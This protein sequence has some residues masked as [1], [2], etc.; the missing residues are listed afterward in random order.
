ME[1]HGRRFS[2]KKPWET[3]IRKRGEKGSVL[4]VATVTGSQGWGASRF[5]MCAAKLRSSLH[6]QFQRWCP[7]NFKS[8]SKF[9]RPSATLFNT[10]PSWIYPYICQLIGSAAQHRA[11]G[12]HFPNRLGGPPV[13]SWQHHPSCYQQDFS[14]FSS[15]YPSLVC[16]GEGEPLPLSPPPLITLGTFTDGAGLETWRNPPFPLQRATH[17]RPQQFILG[18]LLIRDCSADWAITQIWDWIRS[19]A[20]DKLFNLPELVWNGYNLI[21]SR[22]SWG[23]RDSGCGNI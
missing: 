3:T 6:P 18:D 17:V 5:P 8:S 20:L 21:T 22:V 7:L 14:F 4:E 10:A 19:E 23:I 13:P 15:R 16:L 11:L 2:Q 12:E 9:P 1:G